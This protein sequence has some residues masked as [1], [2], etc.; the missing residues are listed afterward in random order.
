MKDKHS[1]EEILDAICIAAPYYQ[2]VIPLDCMI[3]V[4]IG[5]IKEEAIIMERKVGETSALG[6]HQAAATEEITAAM[7]QLTAAAANIEKIRPV[8]LNEPINNING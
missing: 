3:G 2:R 6:E 5:A 1:T 4:T 7:D 8:R